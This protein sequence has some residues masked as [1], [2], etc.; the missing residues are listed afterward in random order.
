[1]FR[2]APASIAASGD[3]RVATHTTAG[4]SSRSFV[5]VAVDCA[6]SVLRSRIVS[7]PNDRQGVAFFATTN[8]RGT[9]DDADAGA[10]ARENVWV[11]QRM[12][13]PSARRIQDLADLVGADGNRRLRDKIG[14]VGGEEND[15]G[16]DGGNR[17]RDGASSYY[18][19][20]FRAH[21]VAREMLNDHAPGAKLRKRLLLFTNRDAPLNATGPEGVEDGRELISAWREFRDVH[22]IDVTLYSLPSRRE[23]SGDTAGVGVETSYRDFDPAFFYDNLTAR[24]DDEGRGVDPDGNPA[25]AAAAAAAAAT[26]RELVP[27]AGGHE[28]VA[29]SADRIDG[30]SATFRKKSRKRRRVRTASLRF[31][32]DENDAIAVALFAPAAEAK[33]PKAVNVHAKDLTELHAETRH[34]ASADGAYVSRENLTRRFVDFGGDGG[35]A[36][37]TPAD[38]ADARRACDREGIHLLGFRPRSAIG[39]WARTSKPARLMVPEE[40]ERRAGSTAAFTALCEAMVAKDRV[41][42][43]AYARTDD[44]FAGVRCVA[45]V[46]CVEA[47]GD[48]DDDDDA[49]DLKIIGLHVIDLPYLD[50][51]RHPELA[52]ATGGVVAGPDAIAAAE[53]AI[54]ANR[55]LEYSPLDVPNPSLS[56]HYRA[57]EIQA[58]DRAWTESDELEAGDVTK[59]PD[60]ASLEAMGIKEKMMALRAAVYGTNHDAEALEDAAAG[61]GVKRSGGGGSGKLGSGL[62][63]TIAD[64]DFR[65]LAAANDLER[66]T[67]AKLKEFCAAN[68]LAVGGAKAALCERIKD[69]LLGS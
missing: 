39:R 46:P 37:V 26:G 42:L 38:V 67:V 13:V 47:A 2:P 45:L 11:E 23:A 28:L 9:A 6:R 18:D 68:G 16:G 5:D 55:V 34:I 14:V 53:A 51:L 40:E 69:H 62:G 31:G 21:H 44:R 41:A 36:I 65:A 43:A 27:Y 32:S 57:L 15:D 33:K 58:L 7:T 1:M 59:P 30:L 20:L 8:A 12:N 48:D 4:G 3:N 22:R 54:E 35:R 24:D 49:N 63:Q 50:D 66:V 64:I 60:A 25:N 19:A 17:T 61:P 10:G 29:C 52:H 56:R